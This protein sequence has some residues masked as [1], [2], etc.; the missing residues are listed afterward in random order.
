MNMI[1]LVTM[2]DLVWWLSCWAWFGGKQVWF[3]LVRG[4]QCWFALVKDAGSDKRDELLL[5]LVW[6]GDYHVLLGLVGS[7]FGLV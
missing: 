5:C 3:G 1:E 2:L 7:N 6:F 4:Q